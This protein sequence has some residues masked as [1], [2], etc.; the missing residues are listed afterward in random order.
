VINS[1]Q[2]S[3]EISKNVSILNERQEMAQGQKNNL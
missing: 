3:K 2:V 1:E